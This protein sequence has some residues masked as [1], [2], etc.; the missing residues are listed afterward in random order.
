[1][2]RRQQG[3]TLVELVIAIV[4]VGVA[5]A[6]L[7]QAMASMSARSADPMLQQQSLALA[8]SYLEE[9]L[10]QSFLDPATGTQCPAPPATRAA[11]DNVCD[12]AGLVDNGA[13]NVHGE[14]LAGLGSY[15]VSVSVTPTAWN[16]LPAAQV[17]YVEVSVRDPLD[18][19]LKLG[20]Y[21]VQP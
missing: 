5:G 19:L 13:R 18:Q 21:R 4:I 14:A 7:Y 20:S 16:G 2:R 6:A 8:E 12:Y 17:L 10:L 3:V 1:M 15:Q 11:Y 9:I